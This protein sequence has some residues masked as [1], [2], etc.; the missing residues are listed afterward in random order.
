MGGAAHSLP[1]RIRGCQCCYRR[2]FFFSKFLFSPSCCS[3]CRSSASCSCSW[4]WSSCSS[5]LLLFVVFKYY[6]M[7]FMFFILFVLL[8]LL[9]ISSCCKCRFPVVPWRCWFVA[10][11]AS[12]QFRLQRCGW[13]GFKSP[14]IRWWWWDGRIEAHRWMYPIL[15]KIKWFYPFI[16]SL[17]PWNLYGTKHKTLGYTKMILP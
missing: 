4:P 10:A 14:R 12:E 6:F 9:I 2:W 1:L 7:A 13:W 16:H 11:N 15:L 17:N 3:L 5:S 8:L